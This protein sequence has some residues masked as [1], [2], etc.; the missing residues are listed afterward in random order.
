MEY[1]IMPYGKPEL[2]LTDSGPQFVGVFFQFF[3]LYMG[4][5][6]LTTTAYHAHTNGQTERF[7]E[8]I[9]RSLRHNVNEHQNDCDAF[10]QSLPYA[11]S[12]QVY[13]STNT[14][15]L[16]LTLSRVLPAPA[17]TSHASAIARNATKTVPPRLPKDRLLGRLNTM[18]VFAD[19]SIQAAQVR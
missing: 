16:N 1:W 9:A 11:Y 12:S 15:P 10:V 3:G 5:E 17:D 14:T 2:L 6:L 13:R 7:K 8:T 19:L 18:R 4:T